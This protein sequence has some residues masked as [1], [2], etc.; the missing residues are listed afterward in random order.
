MAQA[1]RGF[2]PPPEV[3]SYFE[4]KG[5]KPAFSWLD[6]WG[7]EHAH[8]FTV[9]K[10]TELDVLKAFR[11]TIAKAEREGKGFENWKPM[12]REE[13]T[14]LG[15]WGP[16]LVSDP[17][18]AD[19]DK[20]VDFSKSRRLEIIFRSNVSSSRAAGQWQRAQRTKRALPYLLYLRT[21]SGDP[22][23]EH[24]AWVGII[25]PVDDP[26]WDTHF[27]PN[28]WLCKCHVRQISAR[29]A[30]RLLGRDP[31]DGGIFYTS[32]IPDLG[33]PRQF[34]NRRT[35]EITEVPA[36][37]DPGW[38]T[39]P[40]K[41]RAT[42]VLKSL[43]DRLGEAPETV[44]T[45]K[46]QELWRDPF[47][48]VAPLLPKRPSIY[49]PAGVSRPLA[50]AMDAISPVVGITA[51]TVAN[52][53]DSHGDHLDVEKLVHL[54]EVLARGQI[55]DEARPRSRSV[56]ARIGQSLWMAAVRLSDTGFLRVVSF[57][58][59]NDDEFRRVAGRDFGE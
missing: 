51:S 48:R 56:V 19:P 43:E 7:E 26:F 10:A 8:A 53:L 40:G 13:L 9:A 6:V 46:L 20:K 18:G 32:E 15:W 2:G 41:A 38:Q 54:P 52:K 3:T 47:I 23:Q 25:R 37:I 1:K 33:P 50:E 11:D 35:G 27:P 17:S 39:N 5:L 31:Q 36:G 12:I 22:R 4:D 14:R 44:A 24:L 45:E 57:R 42:T 16:R 21:T 28:G 30:E 58:R 29:E 49:L 55:I 34:K 59:T